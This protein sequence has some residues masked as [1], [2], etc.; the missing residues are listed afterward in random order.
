MIKSVVIY[1][2]P[3]TFGKCHR[4]MIELLDDKDKITISYSDNGIGLRNNSIYRFVALEEISRLEIEH[5]QA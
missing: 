2:K 1:T 4:W 5:A 3:D